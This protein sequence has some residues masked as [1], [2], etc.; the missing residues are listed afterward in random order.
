MGA[1]IIKFYEILSGETDWEKV[2]EKIGPLKNSQNDLY[3]EEREP[4]RPERYQS[5]NFKRNPPRTAGIAILP[6]PGVTF[7]FLSENE[8]KTIS[9]IGLS[10]PDEGKIDEAKGFLEEKL[11]IEMKWV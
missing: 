7:N 2:R 11:N 5:F 6:E 10:H 1:P 8:K 4:K 3:L 9:A